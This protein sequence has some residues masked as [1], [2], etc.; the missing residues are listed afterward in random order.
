LNSYTIFV[1]EYDAMKK[2]NFVSMMDGYS[3]RA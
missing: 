3:I 1:V 2:D